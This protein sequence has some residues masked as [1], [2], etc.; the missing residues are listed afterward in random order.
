[1]LVLEELV[2]NYS[3]FGQVLVP[4]SIGG[5]SFEIVV[6]VVNVGEKST[7][8]GLDCLTAF[9]CILNMK[10]GFMR[11]SGKQDNFAQKNE[12][13]CVYIKAT[14]D[15]CTSKFQACRATASLSSA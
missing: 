6:K 8:L 11:V 14:D 9:D 15:G 3:V 4:L 2:A 7:I 13:I 1:M 12:A 5:K 10:H